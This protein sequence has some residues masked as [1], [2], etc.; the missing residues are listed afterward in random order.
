MD[1]NKK[2]VIEKK[3]YAISII[4]N[5]VLSLIAFSIIISL[6]TPLIIAETVEEAI[7]NGFIT[8]DGGLTY[9]H[10]DGRLIFKNDL[11]DSIT[12]PST[13]PQGTG[14]ISK[15]LKLKTGYSADAIFTGAEYALITFTVVKMVT[16]LFGVDD[17][18]SN[19]ISAGFSAGV[20]TYQML[21]TLK[22]G[23]LF[24]L[25]DK[26][27]ISPGFAGIAVGII[28]GALL[29]KK[30]STEIVE[31]SCQPYQPPTGGQDCEICN[32]ISGG[33]SEY[34]CKSL[35]QACELLNVG[36]SDEQCTWVN[37]LDVNSPIIKMDSVLKGYKWSPDTS[38]RPPATGAVIEL[39]SGGCVE[40][41]TPLE[42]TLL[43]DEPAQC[44][45]DYDL[46]TSFD[47][48]SFYIG[49]TNLFS[50]NHTETLS[51]PGPDA[52]NSAAPELKND[53]TY[54]L[55]TR[56][57]DAN[58]NFNQDSYS[59]RF[60][61]DPGPDTTPPRIVDV[62]IPSNSPI[63]FNT[64]SVEIEVYIN[65]PAT[66]K[67]SHENRD[68]DN[69][70]NE[71]LCSMNVWEMN[72]NNVYPCTVT[73][74]GIEDRKEN[75]FY[76][77]CK[78]KPNEAENDRNV[79][80]QSFKYTLIGTQPLN[81]ID[82]EPNGTIKGSTDTIAIDLEIKTDN[83]Y[84][85]GEAICYY[86]T[87]GEE[88]DYIAFLD[89]NSNIHKQRQDLVSGDYTYYYKCVDLGG[90]AA[91]NVTKF[92]IDVDRRAPIVVRAYR[93]GDLKI[94]TNEESVCSYS[95]KDCNFNIGDGIAMPFDLE[96][97]HTADWTLS[98]NYYIRCADEY[99]NQPNPNSCSIVI[100]GFDVLQVEDVI[101]L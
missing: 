78:D 74:S 23:E 97:D 6:N 9:E 52:L 17:G 76:F 5:L 80:T 26:T 39:S 96:E 24:K 75:D 22:N 68:Y 45:V 34:R 90:N 58:G 56:C 48:M 27:G 20:G 41:F 18:E 35:G 63:Q 55:Y 88:E 3:S 31:F 53:G 2:R 38:I 89:T 33:C 77:R 84:L 1:I 21:N 14:R 30:T 47:D 64:P 43:T 11:E 87:T 16:G 86:S 57:Q 71:M 65:E 50:Y 101:D 91:Y 60:C 32:D 93:E 10:P 29:Y 92:T 85:N 73:L 98:N 99:G 51:L 100:K 37:P 46:T 72:N 79:N 15:L 25:W 61:V 81:I 40:A 59:I 83:G 42:F 8:S 69:M 62:S 36:T 12:P 94:I 95:N 67:W 13:S 19:A 7:K 66:C 54:T 44:K 49:G 4:I 28:V 70:E 82:F